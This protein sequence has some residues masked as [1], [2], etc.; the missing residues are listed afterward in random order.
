MRSSGRK[1]FLLAVSLGFFT[2]PPFFTATARATIVRPLPDATIT[3]QLVQCEQQIGGACTLPPVAT[4]SGTLAGYSTETVGQGASL[5]AGGFPN[6]TMTAKVPIG[7]TANAIVNDTLEYV[8][9][10]VPNSGASGNSPVLLGVNSIGSISI[11]TVGIS[12]GDPTN[13]ANQFSLV[14]LQLSSDLSGTQVFNDIANIDYSAGTTSTGCVTSNASGAKGVATESVSVSCGASSATGGFDE[15]GSYT[16]QTND[17][18]LVTLQ[19]LLAIGT[20]N[21]GDLNLSRGGTVEG[22]ATVDP[23]FTVPDGYTLELSPGVGNS[24][25]VS[26][27]PE[28]GSLALLSSGLLPIVWLRRR[29]R[30]DT[31]GPI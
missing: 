10:V 1:L 7:S 6:P 31:A 2:A 30:I 27:V 8:I 13:D 29:A 12:P 4:Y 20:D 5:T 15:T 17:P 11:K 3:T 26:A 19:T 14:Q 18:Y 21:G 24:A 23:I 16:I 25:A 22:V 9:E 28:P